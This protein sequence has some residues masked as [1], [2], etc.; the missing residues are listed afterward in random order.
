MRGKYGDRYAIRKINKKNSRK[1]S[2]IFYQ[3]RMD[4]QINNL[5]QMGDYNEQGK[6]GIT[7]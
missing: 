1:N 7:Q 6:Y 5:L 4:S 3:N 2:E